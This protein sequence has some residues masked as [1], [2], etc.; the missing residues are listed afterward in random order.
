M[1]KSTDVNIHALFFDKRKFFPHF[2][3]L[4]LTKKTFL[5]PL[6]NIKG[7]SSYFSN[8]FYLR[9]EYYITSII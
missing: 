6:L 1:Q 4:C 8:T 2:F 7:E 3:A 5:I 9:N